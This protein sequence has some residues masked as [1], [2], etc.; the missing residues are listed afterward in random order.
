M[1]TNSYALFS[2]TNRCIPSVPLNDETAAK[3]NNATR[4]KWKISFDD[5][6]SGTK[7]IGYLAR[8][9][10]VYIVIPY[11]FALIISSTAY[12]DFSILKA[13]A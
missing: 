3:I 5:I 11:D 4:T 1:G 10:Q 7:M 12:L 6:L 2:V 9:T 13:C 8:F